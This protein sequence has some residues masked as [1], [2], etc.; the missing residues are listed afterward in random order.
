MDNEAFAAIM[1]IFVLI[2]GIILLVILAISIVIIIAR[3]ILFERAGE[4]GWSAIVPIYNTLQLAKIATGEYHLGIVWTILMLA[5]GFCNGTSSICNL[6]AQNGDSSTAILSIISLPF[7][8]L[9]IAIALCAAVIGG[10]LS[11]MFTKSYGQ[12]DAMCIL[13]IFF[14]PIILMIMALNKGT[15]YIGPQGHLRIWKK[16]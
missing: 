12:S 13:S 7:S 2:Y 15:S 4:P 16:K 9:G 10:Y 5:N 14:S 3:W 8:L 11:Y 6:I 1:G